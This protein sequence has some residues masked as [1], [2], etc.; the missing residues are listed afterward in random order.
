MGNQVQ[1]V[2]SYNPHMDEYLVI[3]ADDGTLE[4]KNWDLYAQRFRADDKT[5][6]GDPF[7]ILVAPSNQT[8]PSLVYSYAEQMYLLVWNDDRNSLSDGWDVYA[9]RLI[10]DT[11]KPLAYEFPIAGGPGDQLYPALTYN[12][13]DGNHYL[14]YSDDSA[15]DSQ[16]LD[17]YGIR[18]NGNGM[19][20]GRPITI[21]TSDGRQTTPALGASADDALVT[22]WSDY[23]NAGFSSEIW[24]RRLNG[25]GMPFGPEYT[26]I[27]D[28]GIAR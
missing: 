19:P 21:S 20:F 27:R 23:R 13:T 3:W 2:V 9:M 10:G 16:H 7:P 18:L 8:S 6:K 12:P 4:S 11:G 25:N 14:V 22:T 15:I 24:G 1:P 5:P 26:V 28:G 17:L